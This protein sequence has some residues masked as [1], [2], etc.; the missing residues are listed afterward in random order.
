MVDPKWPPLELRKGRVDELV[1]A[2]P[3]EGCRNVEGPQ[4]CEPSVVKVP[5]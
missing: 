1:L 4:A 5:V 2:V 3:I